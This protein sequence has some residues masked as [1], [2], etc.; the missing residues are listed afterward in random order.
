M[1]RDWPGGLDDLG[2]A[3]GVKGDL[4]AT[5]IGRIVFRV[6][7]GDLLPGLIV[8]VLDVAAVGGLAGAVEVERNGVRVLSRGVDP[9]FVDSGSDGRERGPSRLGAE[10]CSGEDRGV[11]GGLVLEWRTMV[12]DGAVAVRRR[13]GWPCRGLLWRWR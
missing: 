1:T 13:R 5:A 12:V 2:R 11:D 3:I 6:G 8:V 10:H 7:D 4:M 9:G